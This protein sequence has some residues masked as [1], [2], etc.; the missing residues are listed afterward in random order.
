MLAST[1]LVGV[2]SGVGV[3]FDSGWSESPVNPSTPQHWILQI[4]TISWYTCRYK[5]FISRLVILFNFTI[6]SKP[7][8][9]RF[10]YGSGSE[11]NVPVA[12]APAPAPGKMCRLR[13]RIPANK[14]S[15]DIMRSRNWP[16]LRLQIYKV[17]DIQVVGIYDL[18][19]R[20]RFETNR[21]NSAPQSQKPVF[22]LWPDLRPLAPKIAT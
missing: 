22:W 17:W 14:T 16:D 20:W 12:P 13:F 9:P 15:I 2:D 3:G 10:V 11:Q 7:E 4:R 8:P 21:I 5:A 6:L 1:H 18:M 19:K